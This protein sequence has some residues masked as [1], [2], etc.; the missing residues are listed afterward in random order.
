VPE[1]PTREAS[2]SMCGIVGV[3]G[4]EPPEQTLGVKAHATMRYPGPDDPGCLRP[5]RDVPFGLLCTE[6]WLKECVA[7]ASG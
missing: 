7:C 6:W 5:P 3:I 2:A 1:R 4:I